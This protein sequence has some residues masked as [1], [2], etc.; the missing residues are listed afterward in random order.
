MKLLLLTALISVNSFSQTIDSLQFGQT[1]F[2]T[3]LVYDS[4]YFY[5]TD[6]LILLNN[7]GLDENNFFISRESIIKSNY[8]YAGDFLNEFPFAF[9]RDYGFVGYPNEVLIYGLGNPFVNWMSDGVSLNDRFQKS[10]NLNLIQTEDIDSIEIVPLPRGFLY[11][12]YIYPVTVNFITRDFIPPKPYS[13]IRYIQGPDREASVDASFHALV[14]NKILFSFD[15]TNRIKDSTFVNNEFSLWQIKTRLKYFLTNEISLIATYNYNDYKIG[16]NGGVNVDSIA[17]LTDDVNQILY[18]NFLAP[19]NYPNGEIK[20]FQHLP[21]LTFRT[22][23]FQWL[24]SNLSLY[25]R[26]NRLTQN[27]IFINSDL[28]EEKTLGFSFNNKF[29]LKNF[30]FNIFVDFENQKQTETKPLHNIFPIGDLFK[31]SDNIKMF[32]VGGML[33]AK[34]LRDKLNINFFYKYS[35]LKREFKN[36]TQIDS[37]GIGIF[38]INF[39]SSLSNNGTGMDMSFELIDGLKFYVG[40]SFLESYSGSSDNLPYLLFQAGIN[41]SNE[42]L[43]ARIHYLINEYSFNSFY[44]Y[45]YYKQAEK[46]SALGLSLKAKYRFVLLETQNALYKSPSNSELYFVPDVSSKTGLYYNDLLFNNNLDLKTGIILTY[47]GSQNFSS[48]GNDILKVPSVARFDFALIGEIRKAAVVY[49]IIENLFDKKY[50]ITPYYPMPERNF[51]FGVAWEFL[52]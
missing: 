42:F 16:F 10:Y 24:K 5:S 37:P 18:D 12:S 27:N 4:T 21:R 45:N 9:Q 34:L 3:T 38:P 43:D 32:S 40:S 13:R 47:T 36:E 31:F 15:I 52:N 30:V 39:T 29:Y 11:G 1:N 20:T 25:Y 2:D 8:R 48:D 6:S 35:E 44:R 49:F 51:R 19:V 26:F 46:L 28:S 22:N 50:F 33:S 14:S 41:F 23:F 17:S 7:S